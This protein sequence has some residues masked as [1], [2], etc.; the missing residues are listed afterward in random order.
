[1]DGDPASDLATVL[2]RLVLDPQ[3]VAEVVAEP[4]RAL[5]PYR[6]TTADLAALAV[7]LEQ[8]APGSGMTELFDERPATGD[9]P[10]CD[11]R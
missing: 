3:F 7:W 6:L 4:L 8:G 10:T 5:A 1:V 11:S 9:D 2:R